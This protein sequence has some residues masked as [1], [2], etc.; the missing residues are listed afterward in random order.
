MHI[1]RTILLLVFL[2]AG[3]FVMVSQESGP[4]FCGSHEASH[5]VCIDDH[6]RNEMITKIKNRYPQDI[7]RSNG[8]VDAFLHWPLIY[9]PKPENE[10]DQNYYGIS[11]YVDSNGGYPNLNSEWQC[12]NRTYDT[13]YGYNHT[14]LDVYPWPFPW[15]KMIDE[16]IL[17]VAAADGFIEQKTDGNYDRNCGPLDPLSSAANSITIRH[18]NGYHTLYLHFKRNTITS[19]NIGDPVVAGEVLGV[20]G[21]SGVSTGPHLHFEVWDENFRVV[22]PFFDENMSDCNVTV[23][24][25]LWLDQEPYYKPQIQK[26][27]TT[28]QVPRVNDCEDKDDGEETYSKNAFDYNEEFNCLIYLRDQQ[29]DDNVFFRLIEPD[30][31]IYYQYNLNCQT[32]PNSC[33]YYSSSYWSFP[34]S[35]PAGRDCGLWSFEVEFE[36]NYARHEFTI[37][38]NTIVEG[39]EGDL[40]ALPGIESTYAITTPDTTAAYLWAAYTGEIV[41]GQFT[42]EAKVVWEGQETRSICATK[43]FPN[44]CRGFAFCETVMLGSTSTEEEN[45]QISMY[46]NPVTD[47]LLTTEAIAE[48][49]TIWNLSGRM[50]ASV[51]KTSSSIDVSALSTGTY[52]VKFE[53]ANGQYEVRKIVKI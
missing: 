22:E 34:F 18:P 12:G 7:V 31:T 23:E 29:E 21:S 4:V 14:G 37:G 32:T 30:G 33:F 3:Y 50:V 6:T 44:G 48:R 27:M 5:H 9:R 26:V 13:A 2:L 40:A 53:L 52:F 43:V 46:P 36:G 25:S 28:T 16:E 41:G 1:S 49:V 17:V 19:K 24:N 38:G 10:T 35:I 8:Q 20:V 42:S 51:N 15:N 11:N 47:R 45:I 39:I